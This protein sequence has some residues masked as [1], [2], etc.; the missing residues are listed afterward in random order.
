[1]Q[2]IQATMLGAQNKK[3]AGQQ[4]RVKSSFH[5]G[6]SN[7]VSVDGGLKAAPARPRPVRDTA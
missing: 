6:C 7:A 1:M 2:A 4:L 5:R 3:C